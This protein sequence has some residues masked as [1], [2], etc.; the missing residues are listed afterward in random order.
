MPVILRPENYDLW[1]NPAMRD[2]KRALGVL[3]PY[4]GV[5]RRYPVSTR[6]TKYRKMTQ[7]VRSRWSY[8]Q[9]QLF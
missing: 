2:T 6:V 9:T 3:E 5:M 1:L 8:K 4:S 7:L